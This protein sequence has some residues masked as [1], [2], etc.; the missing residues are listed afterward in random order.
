MYIVIINFRDQNS[1][2]LNEQLL[3]YFMVYFCIIIKFDG[4]MLSLK[5]AGRQD[6]FSSVFV[7]I[8]IV[9]S[10]VANELFLINYQRHSHY[11][12]SS[13]LLPSA[14]TENFVFSGKLFFFFLTYCF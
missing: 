2:K 10:L 14:S 13:F 3:G 11:L 8:V 7:F 6:G 1:L 9:V 12:G 4:S 5:Y